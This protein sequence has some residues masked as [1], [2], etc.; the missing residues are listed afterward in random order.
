VTATG[1]LLDAP[2]AAE[3]T[4]PSEA[5]LLVA[6]RAATHFALLLRS[7]APPMLVSASGVPTVWLVQ[8]AVGG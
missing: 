2:L 3:T 4:A 8:R 7:G 1:T 5:G 6:F